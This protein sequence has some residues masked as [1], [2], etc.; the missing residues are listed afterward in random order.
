MVE[1]VDVHVKPVTV[2]PLA[3]D[4]CSV[5][6]SPTAIVTR[7]GRSVITVPPEGTMNCLALLLIPFC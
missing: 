3:F 5:R 1:S 6:V 7:L 2:C 4:A